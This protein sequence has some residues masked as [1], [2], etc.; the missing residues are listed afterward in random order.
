MADAVKQDEAGERY[1]RGTLHIKRGCEIY[2]DN[3]AI[4]DF[5]T[6]GAGDSG[7]AANARRFLAAWNMVALLTTPGIERHTPAQVERALIRADGERLEIAGLKAEIDRL[8]DQ[9][10]EDFKE[11]QRSNGIS[12]IIAERARQIYDKGYD[13]AH[14]DAHADGSIATCAGLIA[15]DDPDLGVDDGWEDTTA[16]HVLTKYAGDRIRQLSIAGALIAAEIDRLRR[17]ALAAVP[18]AKEEEK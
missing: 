3:I 14:D 15:L 17:A 8:R 10:T 13:A 1:T 4:A 16:E 12:C 11:A 6:F 5:W 18:A 7:A 9:T 2:A